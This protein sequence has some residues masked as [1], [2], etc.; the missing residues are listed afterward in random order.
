M[1][2]TILAIFIMLIAAAN[3]FA[4]NGGAIR[5]VVTDESGAKVAAARVI[6]IFTPGVQLT[7][8]TDDSGAFEYKG[9]RAGSYLIEVVAK[10]FSEFTSESIEVDRGLPPSWRDLLQATARRAGPNGA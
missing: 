3:L 10:G 5:G 8:H 2:K 6:L 7:T 1:N 9:L 4:Q